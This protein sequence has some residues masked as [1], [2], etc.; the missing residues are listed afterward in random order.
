MMIT[1]LGRRRLLFPFGSYGSGAALPYSIQNGNILLMALTLSNCQKN[2]ISDLV[3]KTENS[4]HQASNWQ[5]PPAG[6]VKLNVDGNQSED[7]KIATG[8]L[9]I[10]ADG[11]WINGFMCNLGRGEEVKAEL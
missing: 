8:G 9:F 7:G 10:S 1:S 5:P 3:K 2:W 6:I 4:K 11:A